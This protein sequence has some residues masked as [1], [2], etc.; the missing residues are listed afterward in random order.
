MKT[1]AYGLTDVGQKRSEN[2]DNISLNDDIGL[3]IVADGMGGHSGGEIAS[4]LAIESLLNVFKEKISKVNNIYTPI[5]LFR[6][7]YL[8]ATQNIFK[9]GI[10][11][12]L[13]GM[14]TT[15][16]AALVHKNII[17]I[18]N[19][20]DSRAYY[21]NGSHLWQLTEDHSL[22]YEQLKMSKFR[23]IDPEQLIGKNIITRSVGFES[24]IQVDVIQKELVPGDHV[25]MCS[26]GVTGMV[27]DD[28]LF[29][30]FSSAEASQ[31]PKKCIELAN[32]AGGDD[33]ISA[34]F[35]KF[36]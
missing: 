3:Y 5:D 13:Q 25:F 22:V 14:G 9:K 26:D 4:A 10:E 20:G 19:V 12:S 18:A 8:E 36:T 34:L 21:F 15:L 35:I 7:A 29:E 31:V 2:Q 32:L 6:E 27:S 28:E 16:V 1:E 17:Y 11:D 30:L 23:N 24:S 33:N